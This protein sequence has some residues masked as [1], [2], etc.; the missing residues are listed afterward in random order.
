MHK[1]LAG[2]FVAGGVQHRRPEETV[3]AHDVLADEMIQFGLGCLPPGIKRFAA[4]GAPFFQRGHVADRRVDPDIEEL[5]GLA[6][7][8]EAEVGG[9]ARDA[10]AAQR[11]I[12]PLQ[13]LVGHIAR[14]VGG[15]P[16]F[17]EVAER[18]Q[19]EKE[20]FAVAGHRSLAAERAARVLQLFGG[21]GLAACVAGIAVLVLGTA[22]RAGSF[23]KAV[24]QEHGVML[25]VELRQLAGGDRPALLHGLIDAVAE[26]AVFWAVGGVIVVEADFEIGKIL[27]V[28]RVAAGDQ[29]FGRDAFGARAHHDRRAVRVVR[30]DIDAGVAA[31]LLEAH[32]EIGLDVFDEMPEV[33]VA[34]GV[35]QGRGDNH[36]PFFRDHELSW[37]A[38]QSRVRPKRPGC[39]TNSDEIVAHFS[40]PRHSFT[41]GCVEACAVIGWWPGCAKVPRF[42]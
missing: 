10:P 25:A 29:F 42:G 26:G 23:D 32:P 11:L 31:H 19:L 28:L 34:V 4:L 37:Q 38:T 9:V 40:Q 1:D 12:E 15:Y 17:E 30:A 39:G 8:L 21:V 6:G 5:A 13:Q 33:D 20:V 35:R 16:G 3:E 24:G 7:D 22:F 27:R 41:E 36:F 2:C 14:G 18:L